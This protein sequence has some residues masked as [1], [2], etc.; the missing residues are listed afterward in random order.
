MDGNEGQVM[1]ASDFFGG[2]FF[3]CV[4]V[5]VSVPKYCTG[6]HSFIVT[7]SANGGVFLQAKSGSGFEMR[8]WEAY[9]I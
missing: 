8:N 7:F 4:F 1:R 3:L 2:V 6:C 9:K 5:V